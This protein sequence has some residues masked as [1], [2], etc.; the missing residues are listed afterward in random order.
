[1]L[2]GWPEHETALLLLAALEA[3]RGEHDRS[4]GRLRRVLGRNP[5]LIGALRA[6]ISE[7]DAAA[8]PLMTPVRPFMTTTGPAVLWLAMAFVIAGL[9]LRAMSIALGVALLYLV[10]AAY[11]HV[12][13]RWLKFHGRKRFL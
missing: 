12:V 10:Y 2:A 3:E 11:G 4:Y 1:V 9:A 13:F 5:A 7:S 8:H 6:G